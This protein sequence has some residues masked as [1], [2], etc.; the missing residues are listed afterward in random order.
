MGW[1]SI[2]VTTANDTDVFTGIFS[3]NSLYG[4]QTI[5]ISLSLVII[6]FI[7]SIE[8]DFYERF[9]S[10]F[11]ILSI[12]FLLGLFV[13]GNTVKGQT[14]WYSYGGFSIQPS[15]FAKVTT[16][17]A[18]AKLM[19]D[20]AFEIRKI[21][22]FKNVLLVLFIPFVIIL[23]LPDVGSAIVYTAFVFVLLK[24]KMPIK[25]FL[26]AIMGILIFI[27][28][29]KFGVVI[30]LVLLLVLLGI[31]VFFS[32]KKSPLFFVKNG[33]LLVLIIFGITATVI[34]SNITHKKV[35]KKH[36]RDRLALW[37]RLEDD[38]TKLRYL[39]RDYG[40]NNDQ[41]VKAIASGGFY[42]KGF[43]DGDRTNGNFIPEQHTDY[44]FSAVGEEFGFVGSSIVVVLFIVLILRI[45]QRAE[46]QRSRFS[47]IYGY[48][49]ASILFIHFVIN[50]GMVTDLLPTIGIP[51]PFFSYGG[52]SLWGFTILLFIFIR[53]DAN[54]VNEL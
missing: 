32:Y 36:H 4:K 53:L 44:I 6:I 47:M 12:L 16:A 10:I 17:L 30:S 40:Y 23:L 18:L 26:I 27:S 38:T 37:L 3:L 9:A 1:F 14:N 41:S 46:R 52:S 19:S 2:Y 25:Y 45:I 35:L 48:G 24:E 29:V 20:K 42:G 51:L 13:F 7:L 8:A 43:L 5:W 33:I 54:R 28:T 34:A 49:V 22:D 39:K 11:Y 50:I 31:F 15:E 21:H